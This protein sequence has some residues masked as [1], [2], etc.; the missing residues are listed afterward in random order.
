MKKE[1]F[2]YSIT[3]LTFLLFH[4]TANA[5]MNMGT[6]NMNV[7][8]TRTLTSEPSTYYTVSGEWSK[9]GDAISITPI[10]TRRCTITA[11][12][13]GTATVEWMGSINTSWEEMYWTINVTGGDNG[14]NNGGGS[15]GIPDTGYS[16]SWTSNGNYSI[17][18]F[19][20]SKSEYHISSAQELAGLAY[21]VNNGYTT[22][23]GK[24][25]KLDKDIDLTGKNWTT[26]GDG[27]NYEFEG[28]F[29]G[30]NHIISGI[31]I[32]SQNEMQQR[33]GFWASLV[34]NMNNNYGISIKNIRLQGK[35]NIENDK[36]MVTGYDKNNYPGCS[37]VGG[38]VGF[39]HGVTFENCKVDMEVA[40]KRSHTYGNVKLGGIAGACRM[41]SSND[42][43]M[44]Y[45]SHNGPL[46]AGEWSGT[47]SPPNIGGLIGYS[48]L[49]YYSG[50]IEYCENISSEII[51]SQPSGSNG[52][53]TFAI[54][55]LVGCGR[56]YINYCRSIVDKIKI[57]N[58]TQK[59][60]F[61]C[62]G[63]SGA[64]KHQ[65]IN[66][67]SVVKECDVNSVTMYN[68]SG[69][70]AIGGITSTTVSSS[71]ANFS[72]SDMVKTCSVTLKEGYDGSTS[73]SSEQMKTLDFLNELNIY[74]QMN[75]GKKIWT[76]NGNE[77]PYIASEEDN[78]FV[79]NIIL[80]KFSLSLETDQSET[81]MATIKPNNATD[82]SVTWSS[83]NTSVATVTSSGKVTAI[84]AGTAVITCTANDAGGVTAECTVTVTN[85]K[86]DKIV[87][88]AEARV[89]AEQTVY[90]PSGQRLAA[91]RK[92]VNIVG[93][94]KVMIK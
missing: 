52:D 28:A 25:V 33:Y 36:N 15:S 62:V 70:A 19:D 60:V 4:S 83:S 50:V 89:L 40:Y 1:I 13:T 77:Y 32:V 91:P 5:R 20:N 39:A 34:N 48:G 16:E 56:A 2:F 17:S 79:T 84:A 88:P 90:A 51:G 54:G 49:S 44:R 59:T 37:F 10:S 26:I 94:K 43:A 55:G 38:L 85:P 78:I 71:K 80:N 31:Y 68:N 46:Y 92:G 35:V 11:N 61:F 24:T 86:A 53:Y 6:I 73:Y 23:N 41:N 42:V 74:S 14:G 66:C 7:G 76:A 87:L 8:D 93:G 27:Y 22:F 12:K 67:Y 63:G 29:D 45:C 18:W 64:D 69:Y 75:L 9:T 81:L 47:T 72:N 58:G 57:T 3:I 65:T 21:L 82:K 30:Q